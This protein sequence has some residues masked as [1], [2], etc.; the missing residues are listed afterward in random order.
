MTSRFVADT[1]VACDADFRVHRPGVVDVDASGRIEWVGPEHEAPAPSGTT[2]TTERVPGL[3]MPGLVNTHCHSPMTLLRGA[4]DDLPLVRWLEEVL[5]P[6]EGKLTGEDVYWGMT[7]ASAELLRCGVTT[8][9]EMY[10]H[11]EEIARAVDDAGSRV[12]IT[13][14]VLVAPG[15]EALGT[16]QQ[17]LEGALAFAARMEAANERVEVGVAAHGAY[18]LPLDCLAAIGQAAGRHDL[19][20]HIHVAE[21][22]GEAADLEAEHGKSVPALLA[23]IGFFEPARV[24]AAHSVWLSDDDIEIYRRHDVAVAHCPQSNMKLGSGVARVTDMLDAGLRVGLATDGPASNND[25]DLWEEMRL[26]PLLQRIR[27]GDAGALPARQ[28][29]ALATRGGAEALGRDDIGVLEPGRWADMIH[30][31]M[32]DPA[33][34]PVIGDEEVISHLLWSASSRLVDDVWVA[35]RRVVEHGACKTV[36]GGRARAEVQR[37]AERLANA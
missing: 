27:T 29:I 3:L 22:K 19:L 28:A 5:W 17:Q 8:T 20:L 31:R 35:G 13:A 34:V 33:F 24:L 14:P 25:L 11:T 10:F 37:R 12:L 9:C 18:T 21:S 1:V 32:D 2:T 7:L 15:M 4:G 23:D 36:D 26:A 6:R 30:V 16:W